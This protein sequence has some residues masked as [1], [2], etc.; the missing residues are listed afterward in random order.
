M[1]KDLQELIETAARF[2][3][4]LDRMANEERRFT[5]EISLFLEKMSWEM[6]Q[7]SEDLQK[8]KYYCEV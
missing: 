4:R 3:N 2:S 1:N 5:D 6:F 7:H 8:I